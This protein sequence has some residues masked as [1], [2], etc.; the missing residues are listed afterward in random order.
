MLFFFLAMTETFFGLF[1]Q[2]GQNIFEFLK[3]CCRRRLH[4]CRK[5]GGEIFFLD[6]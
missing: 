3:K 4:S 6:T 1:G 2:S 5:Q